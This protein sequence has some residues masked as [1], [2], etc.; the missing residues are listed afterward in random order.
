M[1]ILYFTQF[2]SPENIAAAFR[3]KE[4]ATV[5]AARGHEVAVFACW[6]SYPIRKHFNGYVMERLGD[7]ALDEVTQFANVLKGDMS[8]IGSRAVSREEIKWF[9]D[10]AEVVLSVPAGITGLWQATRRN[11]A[12]FESVEL[13]HIEL[14][15]V[16]NAGFSMDARCFLGTFGAMFGSR[17]SG[18]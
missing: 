18:R 17:R 6:S 10:D 8:I 1:R 16:K 13:Q 2:Y 11:D 5:W 12:T 14:E 3:A 15:Y 9:G 4:H 7:E